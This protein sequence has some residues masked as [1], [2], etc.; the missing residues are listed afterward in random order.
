VALYN[1]G[2]IYVFFGW[3]DEFNRDICIY[4]IATDTWE[5]IS[6]DLKK[7]DFPPRV[8]AATGS[9]CKD[10]LFVGTGFM[11]GSRDFWVEYDLMDGSFK[12]CTSVPMGGRHNAACASDGE[13]VYVAGGWH[14]GDPNGSGYYHSD[15]VRYDPDTD[16]WEHCGALPYSAQN[17]IGF[18]A[19]GTVYFGLGEDS[20]GAM[21]SLYRIEKQE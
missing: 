7:N 5:H 1:E 3:K 2:K 4:D 21:T 15:I 18:A 9:V 12:K 14:Y 8:F 11:H 13:Y 20:N 10:R 16:Q 17:M 19:N 6:P